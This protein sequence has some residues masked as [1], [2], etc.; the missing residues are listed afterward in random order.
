MPP[1]RHVLVVEDDLSLA[2]ELSRGLRASG[3]TVELATDGDGVA[4]RVLDGRF[5]AVVL[6]LMLPGRSGVEILEALQGRV[7]A[8]VVVLTAKTSLPAR[9]EAF[10]AGAADY[11]PKPFFLEELVARLDARLGRRGDAPRVV[12]LGEVTLDLDARTAERAGVDLGLTPHELNVLAWLASRPGKAATR[13]Q[14]V[15]AALSTDG[16]TQERTL[17]SH[18]ARIR[19]KLGPEGAALKT[20][21]GVGY[22]L[23]VEAGRER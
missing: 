17:D 4:E 21:W 22:R 2:T 14:I 19:K 1:S 7:S 5:D 8:P 15:E 20:V 16:D 10:R 18:I 12:R 6:D 23:D 9:L 3:Y 13:A 11:L